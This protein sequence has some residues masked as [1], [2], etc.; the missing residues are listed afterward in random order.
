M[1]VG[2]SQFMSKAHMKGDLDPM[3]EAFSA[4]SHLV[5]VKAMVVH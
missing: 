1:Y 3:R 4:G 2:S 5:A